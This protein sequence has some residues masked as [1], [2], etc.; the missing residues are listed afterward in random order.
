MPQY[1]VAVDFHSYLLL[2]VEPSSKPPAQQVLQYHPLVVEQAVF[3]RFLFVGPSSEQLELQV[4]QFH[5]LV[6]LFSFVTFSKPPAQQVLQYQLV[7]EG[8]VF[9]CVISFVTF[10]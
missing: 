1:Q 2:F 6:G 9:P 3:P 7:V 5:P 10:S 4:R 8:T